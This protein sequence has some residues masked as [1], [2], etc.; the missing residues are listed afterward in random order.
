MCHPW[1]ANR[2]CDR[3]VCKP[4]TG[5]WSRVTPAR[6][7]R[8]HQRRR[9]HCGCRTRQPVTLLQCHRA[10][11]CPESLPRP[12]ES[13]D[14]TDFHSTLFAQRRSVVQQRP[15]PA[16][17]AARSLRDESSWVDR[18]TTPCRIGIRGAGHPRCNARRV[19]T[20]ATKS[21][22]AARCPI[23]ARSC[24]SGRSRASLRPQRF[25]RTDRDR[26][27]RRQPAR[28]QCNQ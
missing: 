5:V 15:H 19:T 25:R 6:A 26:S 16:R 12:S 3:A 8:V 10:H 4:A 20:A 9:Y 21:P 27:P 7:A 23:T 13:L 28:H 14:D 17:C 1:S 2:A 24:D 22:A 18:G 11:D